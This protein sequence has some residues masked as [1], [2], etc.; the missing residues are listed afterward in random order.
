MNLTGDSCSSRQTV[1]KFFSFALFPWLSGI[2]IPTPSR[3]VEVRSRFTFFSWGAAEKLLHRGW[4]DGGVWEEKRVKSASKPHSPDWLA[5]CIMQ[6]LINLMNET[7]FLSISP[8]YSLAKQSEVSE[9]RRRK[10]P[11]EGWREN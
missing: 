8:N 11:A 9:R 2:K 10:E 1:G 7:F 4:T 3:S 6:I 5:Q